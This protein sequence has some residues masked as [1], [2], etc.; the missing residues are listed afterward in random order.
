MKQLRPQKLAWFNKIVIWYTTCNQ[1]KI[2][3]IIAP[4]L[5]WNSSQLIEQN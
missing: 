5:L 1:I 4:V 2:T 3:V